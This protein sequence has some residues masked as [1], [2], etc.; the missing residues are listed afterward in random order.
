MDYL[1][2]F[3]NPKI[4]DF[5]WGGKFFPDFVT[6]KKAFYNWPTNNI[7]CLGCAKDFQLGL[8]RKYITN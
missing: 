6:Q 3:A 5:L 2:T 7:L 1:W 8:F 4:P